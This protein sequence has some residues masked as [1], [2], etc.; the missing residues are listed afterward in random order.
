MILLDTHAGI[1]MAKRH[2][3]ARVLTRYPRLHLS[4]VTLLELQFLSQA[5]RVRLS[6]ERPVVALVDDPRWRLDE[7]PAANLFVTAGQF[8]WTKDPFDRLLAALEAATADAVLL[9]NMPPTDV[10]PL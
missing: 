2:V 5:E 10:L 3:R 1:W 8:A 9:D 7:P 4:P 6:G